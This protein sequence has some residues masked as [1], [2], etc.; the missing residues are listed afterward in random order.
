MAQPTVSKVECKQF[1][2]KHYMTIQ[3]SAPVKDENVFKTNLI[4][5]QKS[6]TSTNSSSPG[7]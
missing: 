7:W 6:T 5:Y 4:Q 1:V 3:A 2:K